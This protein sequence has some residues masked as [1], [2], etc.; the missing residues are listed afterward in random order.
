MDEC[1][2]AV[3]VPVIPA[4]AALA[5]GERVPLTRFSCSCCGYGATSRMAPDRCPMCGGTVWEFESPGPRTG[6]D[7]A[8][9]VL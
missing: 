9:G 8:S 2:P 7:R 1:L 4:L 6:R 5:A 3:S